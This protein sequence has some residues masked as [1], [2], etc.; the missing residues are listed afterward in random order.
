MHIR[1]GFKMTIECETATPVLLALSPRPEEEYRLVGSS[2]ILT[3]PE[4][5]LE[6]YSDDFGNQRVRLVAGRGPLTLWSQC[7]ALDSGLP[8]LTD[9]GAQ[10]HPIEDLPTEALVYLSS[11]RYCESDLLTDEAWRLFGHTAP[12]WSRVQA[13]CD[14]VHDHIT[15]GYQHARPSKTACDGLREGRGVC[16]DFAHLVI[17]FCRA[18]NIPA[19]YVSGYLGD[20]GVPPAGPGDFSAWCEVFLGGRWHTF[21]ARHNIPR[22]GR[23]LMVRGRDAA[24]VPMITSFG[25]TKLTDFTVWTDEVTE[26]DADSPRDALRPSWLETASASASRDFASRSTFS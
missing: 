17:A 25:N 24:D 19:R 8:D 6:L 14:F 23:V 18:L 12:G 20:I 22:I 9:A 2:R 4:V 21:D 10:Q 11:S 7:T 26:A 3:E 1:T 13:I 15:F 5:P 16:R